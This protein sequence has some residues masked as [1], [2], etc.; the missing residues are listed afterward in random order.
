M[1]SFYPYRPIYEEAAVESESCL[2]NLEAE[3]IKL[4]DILS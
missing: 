2:V 3:K 1:S 4:G